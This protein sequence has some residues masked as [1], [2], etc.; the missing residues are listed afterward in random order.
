MV[1]GLVQL[2]VTTINVVI[3]V[4]DSAAM[5]S[6]MFLPGEKKGEGAS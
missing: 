4:E 3:S 2:S 5:K 6:G 1:I